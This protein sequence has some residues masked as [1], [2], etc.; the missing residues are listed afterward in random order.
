MVYAPTSLKSLTIADLSK[1]QITHECN[2]SYGRRFTVTYEAVTIDKVVFHR[3]YLKAKKLAKVALKN[4]NTSE[5]EL[6]KSFTAKLRNAEIEADKDYQKQGILYKIRTAF[7]RFFG[8]TPWFGS[9]VSRINSLSKKI[10]KNIENIPI[11][12]EWLACLENHPQPGTNVDI[13]KNSQ[14]FQET[15]CPMFPGEN[16]T[17]KMV[18]R[19]NQIEKE[20]NSF[21]KRAHTLIDSSVSKQLSDF[22]EN[23]LES[24]SS[25]ERTLYQNMTV[26]K[27]VKR[28]LEKRPL[29]LSFS[30]IAYLRDRTTVEKDIPLPLEDYLSYDE[31]QVS[32]FLVTATPTHFINEG[33][34][35]NLGNRLKDGICEQRGIYYGISGA[36]LANQDCYLDK[37]AY[38]KMME[39]RISVFLKDADNQARELGKK[40]YLHV[41]PLGL[42]FSPYITS[43]S[44]P[45]KVILGTIQ[46][47]IYKEQI[48]LNQ[49]NH[50]DTLNFSRFPGIKTATEEES[51][52]NIKVL[53]SFRD[54]A[55][56]LDDASLLLCAQYEA[57]PGSLPGNGYW[58]NRVIGEG[59][60]P[61]LCSTIAEL[62]NPY[63]NE[64]ITNLYI[65]K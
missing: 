28:L 51:I 59:A 32:A 23:K 30:G 48:E 19:D 15:I 57:N 36:R 55:Q 22:L 31:M 10:E 38:K 54:T 13:L 18:E 60:A 20:I 53:S 27:F 46:K 43:L 1:I 5:L 37:A 7:H 45:L 21:A 58:K 61:A 42:E 9:H 56:K 24:G 47:Q 2:R 14:I 8:S 26:E 39:G 65:Y 17:A 35:D 40:A 41:I 6:I 3:L 29:S 16:Q 4:Q 64:N 62:A 44:A 63:I 12:D 33:E 25:T 49:F 11:S 50:I 34:S 52:G